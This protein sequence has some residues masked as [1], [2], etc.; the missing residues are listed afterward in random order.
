MESLKIKLKSMENEIAEYFSQRQ[1]YVFAYGSLMWRP[2]FAYKN[3]A[4]ATLHGY[5]RRLAVWSTYY[6]GTPAQPGLCFGL[7]AGGCCK[8]MVFAVAPHQR[9]RVIAYLFERE[10]FADAYIPKIATVR[11]AAGKKQ[12]ALIFVV[13]PASKQSAPPMPLTHCLRYIKN[14]HGKGGS[15]I[16]YIDNSRLALVKKGIYSPTLEKLYQQLHKKR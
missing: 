16:D 9:R 3:E 2:G 10:M 6:R 8:G 15:N 4:V 14:G 12:M 13:N 11:T 5:H 1:F 7:V